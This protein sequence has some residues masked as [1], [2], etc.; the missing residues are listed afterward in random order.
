MVSIEHMTLKYPG[1]KGV[2]DIGFSLKQGEVMGYLG[3]NG[4]GKTTTIR[5][6]M[7][8][9]KPDSGTCAIHGL[10]CFKKSDQIKGMTGYLPGEIAF[11]SEMSCKEFLKYQFQLRNLKDPSRMNA[12]IERFDLDT[13]GS[14]RHFS[15]GMK[16]KLGIVTAF[17]SDPEILILDEP[18]SGLDPLMQNEFIKLILEEKKRGKTILI[19]SHMFEEVE[20]TCDNVA[21]IK[22]GRIIMHSDVKGL[23]SS[24]RKSYLIRTP[25]VDKLKAF[26]YEVSE[27]G[28]NGCIVSV[29]G[30][31]IAEFFKRL[32][33]ITVQDLDVKN[34]S[35]EDI[36]MHYYQLEKKQ[37]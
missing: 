25:D 27:E 28:D 23:T 37:I 29:Q 22:D 7:G 13:N 26:G 9:L 11:P 15:K 1:G 21:M 4:S 10:D 12:L 14:I 36:F 33:S 24:R 16:Q 3:P 20:R 17:M 34:Q 30:S 35:L 8:F 2:F 19:S 5:C 32:G 6:L 18:T 31:D